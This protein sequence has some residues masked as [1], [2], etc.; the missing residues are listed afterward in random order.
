LSPCIAA[1]NI[2]AAKRLSP[3]NEACGVCVRVMP[4]ERGSGGGGEERVGGVFAIDPHSAPPPHPHISNHCCSW[5][6]RPGFTLRLGLRLLG[7]G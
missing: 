6:H 2:S 1:W 7:L 4:R 3:S 5:P